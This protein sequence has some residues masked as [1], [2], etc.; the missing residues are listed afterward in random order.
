MNPYIK[1]ARR[2]E[3]GLMG[4]WTPTDPFFS[5]YS[6]GLTASYHINETHGINLQY[7]MRTGGT[8]EYSDQLNNVKNT[9]PL[10]LQNA[11]STKSMT[12]LNYQLNFFY[13]KMSLSKNT[14]SHLST[15]ATAGPALVQIGDATQIGFGLGLGQ[16]FY[17]SKYL[18]LRFDARV[19]GYQG[20]NI[21][22][23]SLANLKG[24]PANSAFQQRMFFDSVLNVSFIFMFP[25]F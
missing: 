14:V 21:L 2:V 23:T 18:G 5:P 10:N 16:K 25:A 20:P 12:F 3:A 24:T 15:F 7:Q 1:T 13:G 9:Q 19:V 8:T 11:P 6:F 4:G 17:F 22:S